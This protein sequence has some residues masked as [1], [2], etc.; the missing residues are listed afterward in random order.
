MRHPSPTLLAC[1][2]F[3][4]WPAAAGAQTLS[5]D[6]LELRLTGRTQIQFNTTSVDEADLGDLDEEIAASTFETRRVRFGILATWDGW[7]TAHLEPDFALG[8][9]KLAYAYVNFGFDDAIQLRVGQF[10]KPFNLFELTSSSKLIAAERGVRIRGL[11]DAFGDVLGPDLEPVLPLFDGEALVGEEYAL[12]DALGYLGQDM[13][14]AVH[15]ELGRFAY[16][17]G[18]F[19]GSGQ[20]R[21]D[22]ND[23]KSFAARVTY[24]PSA[25]VPLTLGAGASYRETNK[26][27]DDVAS[28]ET[29]GGAVLGLD[30]EWGAFRRP[31]LHLMAEIDFGENLAI[32]ENL[33]GAQAILAFH[34]PVAA[35]RLEALEPLFR[36]SFGDPSLDRP[37]DAGLLLTPGLNLYF[38][39]RNMI[40]I[41]WDVFLPLSDAFQTEHALRLQSNVYF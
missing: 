41:D 17:A 7:L 1:A 36:A 24:R 28:D 20:D 37:D 8:S 39:G 10:K 22:T 40:L 23:A 13:G 34:R 25:A 19:N 5:V 26:G 12:L 38:S 11:T 15:G 30:A 2:A 35:G 16:E 6:R 27:R 14:A 21:R 4:L 29:F 18:I 3:A 31:G 33:L 32:G 9:L